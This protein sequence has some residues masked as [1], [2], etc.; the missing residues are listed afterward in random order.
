MHIKNKTYRNYRVIVK[1]STLKG[2]IEKKF[3]S[4]SNIIRSIPCINTFSL[5]ASQNVIERLIEYPEVKHIFFDNYAFLCAAGI[6]SSN[7]ASFKTN[8][9][10][11]GKNIG[12]GIIDSGVFPHQDLLKP[13]NRIS[14]FT[15][16]LNGLKYPYDDNG[17]GTFMSGII[18][19]S[20]ISS[21][22]MYRGAAP[23]SHIY[24]VKAFNSLGRS[25]ISDVLYALSLI[26]D[27]ADEHKIKVICLPCEIFDM[28]LNI[29]KLFKEMFDICMKRN[30]T[31][32]VPAGSNEN[33]EG[34]IRGIAALNNCITV[35]G[36]DTQS[37]TKPYLYSSSGPFKRARKPDICAACVNICSLNTNR[38]YISERNGFK[39]YPG[40]LEKPYTG[41]TGTSVAAAYISAVCAL[42]YETKPN[43]G[44][45][46][47]FALLKM[48]SKI[49][50]MPS[51][52]QGMGVFDI[53]NIK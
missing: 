26:L 9:K 40:I 8:K 31:V 22:N 4:K 42:L 53:N 45:K 46:D 12:I 51:R 13:S 47:I 28:D 1:C 37:E 16:I 14:G 15:D 33:S 23:E 52:M 3:H 2:G 11:T 36:I 7:G 5:N 35:G 6:L 41:F 24:M 25:Y 29:S 43:L 32:V 30:I 49:L 21:K 17:H 34:S 18:C 27:S 20:G 48:S 10:Y 19:G 39:I 50:K 44:F 38:E